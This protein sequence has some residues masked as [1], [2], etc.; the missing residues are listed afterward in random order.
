M[1][2]EKQVH[3]LIFFLLSI[4]NLSFKLFKYL[5]RISYLSNQHMHALK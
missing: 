5:L 3:E 1:H 2:Q 4:I